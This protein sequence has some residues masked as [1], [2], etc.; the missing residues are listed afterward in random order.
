MGDRCYWEATVRRKDS[1][2]FQEI[3]YGEVL[4]PG[5]TEF[6]EEMNYA[7]HNVCKRAANEGLVFKVSHGAGGGYGAGEFCGSDGKFY[8]A[9]RLCEGMLCVPVDD[10]GEPV[11]ESVKSVKEYM[12]ALERVERILKRGERVNNERKK[13]TRA[14]DT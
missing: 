14:R 12:A 9:D 5:K 4:H 13:S 11:A 1:E 2:R 6:V 8:V 3:V 10:Y 7:A